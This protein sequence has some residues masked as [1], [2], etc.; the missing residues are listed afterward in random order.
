MMDTAVRIEN[1]GKCYRIQRGRSAQAVGT[2]S[3]AVTHWCT[4]PIRALRRGSTWEP[5]EEFW[6]VRGVN[7]DVQRGEVVGLVGRNGA[8][9]STLLKLV[10]RITRPTEGQIRLRG[11][12]GSLLEVGTG[13]HP[14]LSGR[15]NIYLNGAILGMSR[16]EIRRKFD[17][18]VDFAGIEKFL[19]VPVKRYSSGMHVRLGFAVAAHLN[20]E[21]LIVD[22][23]LAVGDASFQAKCLGK[24]DAVSNSGR[25][26]L[27]VSHNMAAILRLCSRVVVL[28]RGNVCF[29]GNPVEAA[30]H[31]VTHSEAQTQA[32]LQERTDRQGTGRLRFTAVRLCDERGEP[33]RRFACG[34]SAHIHLDY[35]ASEG[36]PIQDV[37]VAMAVSDEYGSR[38]THLNNT[39]CGSPLQALPGAGGTLEVRIDRLPLMPGRYSINIFCSVADVVADW[40][41]EPIAYFDVDAGDFFG[42][43]KLQPTGQGKFLTPH[44]FRLAG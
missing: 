34:Q 17:E 1:V 33:V 16:Q 32:S 37:L 44:S 28:D 23:V 43:G 15:E 5:K 31:Y 41:T 22:E 7:L 13:F 6:A 40:I 21:I 14:E 29:N 25:T 39:V 11:R 36:S 20:P 26:V 35:Q 38:V 2:F 10:S 3:E 12:V 8:G 27:F 30:R 24:L 9:K 42:S 19:E 4:A 18:I